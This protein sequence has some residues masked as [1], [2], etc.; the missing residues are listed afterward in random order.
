MENIM[1]KVILIILF[2]F[3]LYSNIYAQQETFGYRPSDNSDIV[4][5]VFL[6]Q[7]GFVLDSITSI[8]YNDLGS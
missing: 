7:D 6:I 1:A 4:S 8:I 3:F 2:G 5:D